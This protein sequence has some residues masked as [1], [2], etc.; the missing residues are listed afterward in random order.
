MNVN[1][2]YIHIVSSEKY[3][4]TAKSAEKVVEKALILKGYVERDFEKDAKEKGYRTKTLYFKALEAKEDSFPVGSYYLQPLGS[5]GSPDILVSTES[6]IDFIEVKAS[7]TTNGQL[8]N[9]HLIRPH[10]TYVLSDPSINFIVKKG[11]E[12]MSEEARK[13]LKETDEELRRIAEESKKRLLELDSNPQGWHYYVR[14]MY[15]HKKVHSYESRPIL[16]KTGGSS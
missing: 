8:F 16:H 10:F 12:L 6:G 5:Q 15:S 4:G 2:D 11:D 3:Q 1:H 14:A 13:I 9:G 7:Q